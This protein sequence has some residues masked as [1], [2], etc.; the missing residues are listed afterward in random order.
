M[1]QRKPEI[2]ESHL[3]GMDLADGLLNDETWNRILIDI[4]SCELDW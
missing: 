4:V 1:T 2:G 3:R